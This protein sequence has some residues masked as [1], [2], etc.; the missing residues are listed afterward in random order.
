MATTEAF[1]EKSLGTRSLLKVVRDN[2]HAF[3]LSQPTSSSCAVITGAVFA[4]PRLLSLI[5]ERAGDEAC[6]HPAYLGSRDVDLNH[7]SRNQ[8]APTHRPDSSRPRCVSQIIRDIDTN[9]SLKSSSPCASRSFIAKASF[10]I[11]GECNYHSIGIPRC[12]R[13]LNVSLMK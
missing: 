7:E 1:T 11:F 12:Y 3:A 6:R 8:R 10:E 2:L 4:L 5:N 13:L 9:V